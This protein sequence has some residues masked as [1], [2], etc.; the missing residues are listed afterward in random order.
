MLQQCELS[1]TAHT[2]TSSHLPR[3]PV[4]KKTCASDTV[5]LQERK[6]TR[7]TAKKGP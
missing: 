5:V 6:Q 3:T 2:Y 1:I 7:A 4:R